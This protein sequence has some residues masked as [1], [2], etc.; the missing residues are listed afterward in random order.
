MLNLASQL[1][2]NLFHKRRKKMDLNLGDITG[3]GSV[4]DFAKGITDK[5]WPPQADPNDKLKAQ[6]L[7]Q[8]AVEARDSQVVSAQKEIIV[9]EMQ[10]GDKFTKRARPSVVYMGLIFIGLVHVILPIILKI[11]LV[12]QLGESVDSIKAAQLA[13][14]KDLMNLSLPDQFWW[15]WGSVVSVWE[16]GRSIERRGFANK[17]IS[18]IAGPK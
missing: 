12:I 1:A 5:I 17:V 10:Q 16:I 13:E 15:A 9:A 11:M 7:I 6:T 2:Y 3:W 18:A 4:F 14:L 8:Q